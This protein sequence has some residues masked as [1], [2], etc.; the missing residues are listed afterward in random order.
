MR[1]ETTEFKLSPRQR[2]AIASLAK[3][4][5]AT[6]AAR[7]ARVSRVT[8]WRWCKE[9]GFAAELEKAKRAAF[10]A[11]VSERLRQLDEANGETPTGPLDPSFM[12]DVSQRLRQLD[13]ANG[14]PPPT[15]IDLSWITPELYEKIRRQFEETEV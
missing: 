13:E 11:E 2:R 14:E 10:M 1:P 6:Q 9:P 7:V 4:N 12:A 15:P 8:I 5:N 3:H